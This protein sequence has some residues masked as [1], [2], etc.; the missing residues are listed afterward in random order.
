MPKLETVKVVN[1]S[2]E[3]GF[4]VINKADF[5]KDKHKVFS[6]SKKSEQKQEPKGKGKQAK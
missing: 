6:E 5:D 1:E 2:L 3:S 4:M